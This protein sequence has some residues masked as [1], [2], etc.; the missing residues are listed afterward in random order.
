MPRLARL[1]SDSRPEITRTRY[2]SYT[3]LYKSNLQIYKVEVIGT[4]I[5]I[6]RQRYSEICEMRTSC[7]IRTHHLVPNCCSQC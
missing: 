3:Q 4:V 2:K 5:Q 6:Q 7:E 1:A